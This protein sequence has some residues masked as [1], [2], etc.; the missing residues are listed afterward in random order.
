MTL[1]APS[2]DELPLSLF[3]VPSGAMR[4]MTRSPRYV[5]LM[6]TA[7]V[8]VAEAVP[9]QPVKVMLL[10][11]VARSG[12]VMLVPLVAVH[13][14]GVGAGVVLGVPRLVV[15][16]RR[17]GLPAPALLSLPVVA[18]ASRRLVTWAGVAVGL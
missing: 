14:A 3:E 8:P 11:A 16:S 2:V 15:L 13:G 9:V 18:A 7:T 6:S 1:S 4:E 17:L 5:C 10:S 12:M